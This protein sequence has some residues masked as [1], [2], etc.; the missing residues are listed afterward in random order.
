MLK[1]NQFQRLN[2]PLKLEDNRNLFVN[3]NKLTIL[4]EELDSFLQNNKYMITKEFSEKILFSQEIKFNNSIEGYND[5][6]AIINELVANENN[7]EITS[8]EKRR[9]IINLYRGYKYILTTPDI[10][11]DNLKQL[12]TMLSKCLLTK[13]E[14]DEMDKYYRKNQVYIYYSSNLETPPDEGINAYEI[15]NYMNELFKYLKDNSNTNTMTDHYIKSQV[16]HFY[17]VYIHPYY[18]VNG[19][20]S[21]TMSM[22][23]LLNNKA[24]PYLIFNR[25]ITLNKPR[26]YT[27]IRDVKKF[28]N[29]SYFLYY[30]L[31]NV[32]IEL[33]KE[34]IMKSIED[35]CNFNLTFSERQTLHYILS[36]KS[37]NTIIDFACFYN[38]F[39]D[40]KR[41]KQIYD[42]MLIPLLDKNIITKVRSTNSKICQDQMNF[43]YELNKN[44]VDNDPQKIT[45]LKL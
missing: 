29:I 19:R 44:Y 40:K 24:Y 16:A 11:K 25:A 20:T 26:Y 17:F 18:D 2:L 4:K 13:Q 15:D 31:E 37:L 9:R 38:R 1:N 30:M 28:A 42:E 10:D 21:R 6:V 33:E 39:N 35:S 27:I 43:V 36:S 8:A 23:Y 3:I 45:R 5:D 14:I 41:V 34:Y 22:W 32:K 12:Y 7:K